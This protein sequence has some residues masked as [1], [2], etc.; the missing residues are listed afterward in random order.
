MNEA[1]L[2]PVELENGAPVEKAPTAAGSGIASPD[3]GRRVEFAVKD[4]AV[5]LRRFIVASLD[6]FASR[7]VSDVRDALPAPAVEPLPA[8]P[9]AAPTPWPWAAAV[10]AASLVA[11]VFA[12]GW[13]TARGDA[14]R[15]RDEVAGLTS[16]NAELQRVRADLA[17]TVKDLTADLAAASAV[18]SASPAAGAAGT[19]AV[20]AR[21]EAVPYGEIPFDRGRLDVLRELLSKLEAQGF[22]G[23]VKITSLAGLYCLSGNPT[24]GFA[25]AAAALPAGK[26]DLIGN[27]FEESLSGQQ[28]QSLAFAN[29]IAGVRQ[30]TSGAITVAIET[31]G[32]VRASTPYP[33]RTETLTAGEWNRAA[34]A[35]N[36][37]EFAAEAAVG[38]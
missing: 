29:L 14:S 2:S 5:D 6:S 16:A 22:H 1:V 4:Q 23:V 25:P 15:A 8:P 24:D 10:A 30:R 28:R 26:C 32:S 36:R 31:P 13:L 18:N 27:P 21:V 3:W 9:R 34:A 35:N 19:P 17:A 12:A 33:T 11:I 7:I 37:V 20:A 38:Q